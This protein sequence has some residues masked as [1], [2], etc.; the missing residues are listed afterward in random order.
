M[1]VLEECIKLVA[2]DPRHGYI[3]TGEKRANRS[4]LQIANRSLARRPGCFFVRS[5]EAQGERVTVAGFSM[6]AS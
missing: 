6:P 2:I 3:S 4:A 5:D 1:D